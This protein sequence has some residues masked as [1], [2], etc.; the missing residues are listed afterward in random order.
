VFLKTWHIDRPAEVQE[1]ELST[2]RISLGRGLENDVQLDVQGVS[3]QH[4]VVTVEGGEVWVSDQ[5]STN[6]TWAG[7]RRID[8]ARLLTGDRFQIG[9]M[10]FELAESSLIGP[11]V[12]ED[13]RDLQVPPASAVPGV[14]LRPAPGV[15]PASVTQVEAGS[16]QALKPPRRVPLRGLAIGRDPTNDVCLDS[17]EVSRFHALV[18]PR[19]GAFK[20]V[21]LG[22]RNG[23]WIGDLRVRE[24]VL[25]DA[26]TFRIGPFTFAFHSPEHPDP[27]PSAASGGRPRRETQPA[28]RCRHRPPG[29]GRPGRRRLPGYRRGRSGVPR[30]AG[31]R[32]LRATSTAPPAAPG[33]TRTRR[34]EHPAWLRQLGDLRQSDVGWTAARGPRL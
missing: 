5:G 12:V 7:G 14:R 28:E 11:T 25:T 24:H 2:G 9:G 13:W 20:L 23:I 1:L 19:G 8:R 22:S 17:E 3:R 10:V 4:A 33:A 27:T 29:G 31:Q 34:P 16:G 18:E 32:W 30:V 21:D 6:G 26:D 15:R